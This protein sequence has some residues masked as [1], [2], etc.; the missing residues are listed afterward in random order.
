MVER[1][2]LRGG[3]MPRFSAYLRLQV[4]LFHQALTVL[5]TVGS[6]V[7]FDMLEPGQY[8]MRVRA[9]NK[10]G[11]WQTAFDSY[12]ATSGKVYGTKCFYV[13]KD[14]KIVEDVYVE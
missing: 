14:K 13:T 1:R 6:A 8:F 9:K 2:S 10:S 7:E 11:Y 12:I 3:Y 4:R 5:Y